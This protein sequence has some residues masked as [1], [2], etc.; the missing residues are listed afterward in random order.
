MAR[1]RES[2]PVNAGV[3][4]GREV[5]NQTTKVAGE[6]MTQASEVAGAAVD[7]MSN[8]A[9]PIINA[10]MPR[11]RGRGGSSGRGSPA[12]TTQRTIKKG[13]RENKRLVR[14][15]AEAANKVTTRTA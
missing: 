1:K 2:N 10:V 11:G 6:V 15:E 9:S 13:A 14:K 5:L 7:A 8:M 12:S 4:T 3:K